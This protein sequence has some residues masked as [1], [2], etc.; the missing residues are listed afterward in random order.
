MGQ[1]VFAALTT[2]D[3][4]FETIDR[5]CHVPSVEPLM[6]QLRELERKLQ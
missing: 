5:E 2:Q 1:E 4:R 3:K 6:A